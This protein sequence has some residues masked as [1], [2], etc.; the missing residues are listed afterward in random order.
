[1]KKTAQ[2]NWKNGME[3]QAQA[4]NG[5]LLTLDPGR[6]GFRP[7]QLL[8]YGLA[9]CTGMDVIQILEKKRVSV[10]DFQVRVE[11]GEEDA[12]P[13]IFNDIEITYIICGP[14]VPAKAVE[15][16]IELS[17]TKYC[18]VSHML[19]KTATIRTKY[20]IIPGKA[21]APE[22]TPAKA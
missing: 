7:K 22:T 11:A 20:E 1:M 10:T 2:V 9:G 15:R 18:G 8:L 5:A 14:D 4:D 13:H 3:F 16:A 12:D 21:A 19:G 6:V 17:Q